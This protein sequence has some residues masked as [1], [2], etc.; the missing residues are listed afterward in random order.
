MIRFYERFTVVNKEDAE[1]K[2]AS[3]MV[4]RNLI[5]VHTS[6]PCFLGLIHSLLNIN[7]GLH[8]RYVT[9]LGN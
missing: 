4:L 6:Q 5:F 3:L 2:G 7:D 1:K 8:V 9:D